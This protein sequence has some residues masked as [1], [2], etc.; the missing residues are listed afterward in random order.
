M[1]NV[2]FT[3][4]VQFGDNSITTIKVQPLTFATLTEMWAQVAAEIRGTKESSTK[5]LQRKRIAHQVHFMAGDKRIIADAANISQLPIPV[6]RA[7]IAALDIGEG[8]AG[9]IIGTGDGVQAPIL[10]KLGNPIEA[11]AGGGKKSKIEELE[12]KATVFADIEDV[13]AVDGEVPQALELIK[14]IG[15]PVDSSLMVL[16]SWAVERISVADGVTITQKVLPRFLE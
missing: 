1:H 10:Y 4:P 12:F 5:H 16:P 6:A 13:L 8:K 9:E 14:R 15:K 3:L 2:E 7:I 11:E